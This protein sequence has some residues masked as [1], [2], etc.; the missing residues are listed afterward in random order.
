MDIV[1]PVDYANL[2][3]AKLMKLKRF[4]KLNM[5]PLPR[6]DLIEPVRRPEKN[7]KCVVVKTD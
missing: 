3:E 1:R 7:M 5:L 6:T 2:I 4:G